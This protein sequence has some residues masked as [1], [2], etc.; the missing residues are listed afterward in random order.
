MLDL[1]TASIAQVG[2]HNRSMHERHWTVGQNRRKGAVTAAAKLQEGQCRLCDQQDTY[3]HWIRVCASPALV[4]Q[5]CKHRQLYRDWLPSLADGEEQELASHLLLMSEAAEGYR[6]VLGNWT[7]EQYMSTREL[8]PDISWDLGDRVLRRA[9]TRFKDM[10][11]ELWRARCAAMGMKVYTPPIRNAKARYYVVRVGRVPGVYHSYAESRS[12]TRG[13][14]RAEWHSYPTL[15]EAL[16]YM[17]EEAPLRVEIIPGS[18][19]LVEIYTDGS[20][21]KAPT[22][23]GWGYVALHYSD[24]AV[25]PLLRVAWSEGWGGVLLDPLDPLYLGA[26][27][28]TNNTGELSAIGA[29]L[30]L[31]LIHI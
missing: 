19:G 29:A 16:A 22:R 24:G 21:L 15:A 28:L 12:Q 7:M 27:K 31:S 10:R 4:T 8:F 18:R 25:D 23:A 5:R 11:E 14:P 6:I 17:K 2:H 3:D 26:D 1:D 30:R 13:F 9:Y 20:C